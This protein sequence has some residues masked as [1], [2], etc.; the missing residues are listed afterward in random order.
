MENRSEKSGRIS[1]DFFLGVTFCRKCPPDPLQRLLVPVRPP[2]SSP[3]GRT[4]R[5]ESFWREFERTFLQKGSLKKVF[6]NPSRADSVLLAVGLYD[7][8]ELLEPCVYYGRLV[9]FAV[10]GLLGL[11]AVAGDADDEGLVPRYPALFYGV[12]DGRAASGL[13]A[14]NLCPVL[15]DKAQGMEL[16]EGLVYLGY[17][18]AAGHGHDD[19]VRE[20]PAE[21]LRYLVAEGLGA[22]GVVRPDVD[23]DEGPAV[24]SGYL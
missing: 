18:R 2:I 17:E 5:L 23:V 14:V 7:V 4:G 19:V 13:R 12:Y 24:L 15:R 16:L 20:P 21:L 3:G 10:E 1:G 11:E 6:S 8:I 9:Q 22:L